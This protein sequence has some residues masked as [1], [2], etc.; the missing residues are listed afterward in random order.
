MIIIGTKISKILDVL[1]E[2]LILYRRNIK[3]KIESKSFNQAWIEP[4]KSQVGHI[5]IKPVA[6]K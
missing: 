3:N 5:K 4:R 6:K 1:G 2:K